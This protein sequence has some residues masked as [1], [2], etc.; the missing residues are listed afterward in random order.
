[1]K[2]TTASLYWIHLPEHTDPASEG[3]LGVTNNFQARLKKHLNDILNN[4]HKNIHLTNAAN[5]YGW[6]NLLKEVILTD[7]EHN[8]YLKENEL[9]P[10]IN[11]GWNIATGGHKGPGRKR[12]QKIDPISII[13]RQETIRLR[14]HRIKTG[15]LTEED[16]VFLEKKNERR[17][18]K[19]Q[20]Q[21]MLKRKKL[22]EKEEKKQKKIQEKEKINQQKRIN[23]TQGVVHTQQPNRPLCSNCKV[24]PSKSNG[25]SKYGFKKYH[26]YCSSCSKAAYNPKFGFTLFKKN[27]CEKCNFIPE[28]SC[29]LDLVYKD[30]NNKNKEKT[31]IKTLCAN[32]SRLY[33]KKLKE[34]KKTIYDITV[35]ADVTI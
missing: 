22:Q 11:I 30:G 8:C 31:N 27:H 15:N 14:N 23:R 32:C 16:K 5:K 33:S 25:I 24:A 35:D 26:K 10:H 17:F 19:L 6:D 34:K 7:I 28:D 12:G 18:V 9:R 20:Q 21:E 3:Y 1:M 13:K 29:Q 2:R 4:K